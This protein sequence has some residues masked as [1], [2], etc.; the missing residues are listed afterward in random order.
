MTKEKPQD[1]QD[2]HLNNEQLDTVIDELGAGQFKTQ[3]SQAVDDLNNKVRE[4]GSAG[5]E[6]ELKITIK[7]KPV[8]D[9]D[10]LVLSSTLSVKNP[11][12][13][14]HITE[15]LHY[16]THFFINGE[17]KMSAFVPDENSEGQK[18]FEV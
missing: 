14:G 7:F 4:F 9:S 16:E 10:Q 13:T 5:K 8:K 6:G 2:P 12:L 18:Q 17:S 15:T 1:E 3:L 11:T